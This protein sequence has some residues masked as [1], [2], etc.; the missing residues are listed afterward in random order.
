[1]SP[2]DFRLRHKTTDRR[3]YDE[4][5]KQAGT[6]EVIFHDPEGFLTEG[7]F[8]NIFVARGDRLVTPP[9]SRGLLPGIFRQQLI[10]EGDAEEGD[11]K[12]DDLAG[13]FYL[14]N[15]LRGLLKARLKKS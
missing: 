1:V 2:N 5:R 15:S 11:L 12:S 14:G 10:D 8:S 13:G 4:P 3:F 6:W 7:S 9:L